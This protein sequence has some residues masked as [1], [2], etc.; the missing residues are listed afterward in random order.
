[1]TNHFLITLAAT[2]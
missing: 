2:I 1:M